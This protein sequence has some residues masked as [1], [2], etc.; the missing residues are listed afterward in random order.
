MTRHVSSAE[1]VIN[2]HALPPAVHWGSAAKEALPAAI[3]KLQCSRA[4]LM[5]S[6]TLRSEGKGAVEEIVDALGEMCVGV[7]HGMPAHTPRD[8]VLDAAQEAKKANADV[9]VTIGGG[10]LTDG[11]KVVRIALETGV[12]DGDSLGQYCFKGDIA[13]VK[14][15]KLIPQV[16]VPTTLSAGEFAPYAGCTD[17]AT[18][19][20]ETY[21]WLDALP[22]AIVLDP[23]LVQLT[24]EWLFLSTGL[25][26]VDHC[27]ECL[28]SLSGNPYSDGL[29]SVA[30]TL[31]VR[32]L[33]G[34]KKNPTDRMQE[35][36]VSW[37]FSRQFR[38]VKVVP[39]WELHMPLATS[40]VLLLTSLTAT[41]PVS[42]C[43]LCCG[44]TQRMPRA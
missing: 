36:T 37:G 5:V 12:T 38:H 4:F 33:R 16:S 1:G 30:L 25:R 2:T 7:W 8:A 22:K 39:K 31:L 20:K 3:K 41:P 14:D 15:T 43:L 26:S 6:G 21:V 35:L 10:S 34:V 40:W 17:P 9:I 24:S 32:G 44:G 11:A 28:C 42:L 13:A 19:V 18:K 27:V 23:C 29:A